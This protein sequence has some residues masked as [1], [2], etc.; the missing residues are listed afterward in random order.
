MKFLIFG[1]TGKIG[2]AVA[3]D[4]AK[5]KEVE[6]VGI[7]G[8]HPGTLEET[9]EWIGSDK[10]VAH[11]L[12]VA[13]GEETK[14][15]MARYDVGVIA[16]P[17]RRT[18][19]KVVET[20]IDAGLN[21]VDVLEEYH[22]RPEPH[23]TEGLEVP[24]GMTL[25]E[26][27]EW[28]HKRAV[29]NNVLL[30]DGIGFAPGLSNIAVGEGIRKLDR[31]KTAIARVGGI[32]SKEAAAKHPLGYMITWAFAHVLRE[33]MVK[34][35]VMK[36]GKPLEV[37]AM[38]DHEQFRFKQLGRDEEL[39]CFVTPGMPSFLFT[40]PQLREFSE[41]TIRWPGHWQ[42][43]QT[44]KK[45]GLLD[46]APVEFGGTKMVPRE[47]LVSV[48]EPR[49][50]PLKGD[51]DVCVMWNTVTGTKGGKETRIDYYMWEEA[52]TGTGISAMARVTGFSAAIAA[53]L[54]AEG[55]IKGKG[56]VPP[57][58]CIEEEVYREF[59]DELKKR[60]ITILEVLTT[61]SR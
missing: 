16:L 59:L 48:L 20:A 1:G 34:L 5:A 33:Y 39:E 30:I 54:L 56:L 36:N 26:Y 13:D 52:D 15:L 10:V 51:T 14:K 31:A 60:N 55:K 44:L 4:L 45:C 38:S 11:A 22:R 3:W 2:S 40:R 18:S 43:I 29:E 19:Y 35:M 17:D 9:K 23:E 24:E 42:G 49:L 47:F 37:E 61:N 41:K 32:P 7:L 6:V 25:E 58:D 28:L 46:L 12:D 8:K 27:G 21:I 50:R 53:K 57:E